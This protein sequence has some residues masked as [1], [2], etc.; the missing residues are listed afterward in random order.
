MNM[1]AP[2]RALARLRRPSG[3]VVTAGER[4]GFVSRAPRARH[5][6]PSGG[7]LSSA[8]PV[9]FGLAVAA[10]LAGAFLVALW[11]FG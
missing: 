2:S 7:P 11:L 9:Q 3:L 6:A 10:G 5:A 8:G 1:Q 4:L